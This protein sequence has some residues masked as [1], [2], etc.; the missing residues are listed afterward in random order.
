MPFGET[1]P[2]VGT[3]VP[4]PNPFI[5]IHANACIARV[6]NIASGMSVEGFSKEYL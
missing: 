1:L 2:I 3:G 5:A 4:N 6:L